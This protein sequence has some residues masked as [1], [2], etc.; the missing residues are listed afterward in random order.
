MKDRP[1]P[2]HAILARLAASA[3]GLSALAAA[4]GVACGQDLEPRAHVNTPVGLEE[5]R[6]IL[7][8]HVGLKTGA[9]PLE[10]R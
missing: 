3:L 1:A 6:G 7:R 8:L 5:V 9:V 2:R 10:P 4:P